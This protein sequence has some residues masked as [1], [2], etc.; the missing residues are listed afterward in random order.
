MET[1]PDGSCRLPTVD[2]FGKP[3]GGGGNV[4]EGRYGPAEVPTEETRSTS[5]C[6]DGMVLGDDS[7]CY[8]HIRND[9]RLYPRGRAPLLTG[10]ERNAITIAGQAAKKMGAA[11]K[12]LEGLGL[13]KRPARRRAAP[14]GHVEH[15]HHKGD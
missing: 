13:I 6:P 12:T 10:G 4:V 8:K 3:L 7:L 5:I 1:A 2:E 9:D 15:L 11:K 14:S